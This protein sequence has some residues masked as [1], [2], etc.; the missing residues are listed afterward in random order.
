[1]DVER[2]VPY[3][4]VGG[5]VATVKV[6]TE[7]AKTTEFGLPYDPARSLLGIYPKELRSVYERES[8]LQSYLYSSMM[9]N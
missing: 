5:N 6:S 9:H 4:T 2:N 1:M 7:S 3:F 8:N